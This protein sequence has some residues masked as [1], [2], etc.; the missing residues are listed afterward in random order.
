[1]VSPSPGQART[2]AQANGGSILSPYQ[3]PNRKRSKDSTSNI[4][5]EL[6]ERI[7]QK[8]DQQSELINQ[9]FELIRSQEA[10]LNHLEDVIAKQTELLDSLK[11]PSDEIEVNAE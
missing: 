3:T 1:M 5:P 4:N 8:I 11:K 9:Q 7:E 2:W 6:I 10:K